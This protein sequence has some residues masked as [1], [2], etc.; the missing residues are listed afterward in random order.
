MNVAGWEVIQDGYYLEGLLLD[1]ETIWYTDIGGSG[2]ERLGGGAHL[3]P[4][5]H[6]IGGLLLNHD[7]CILVSG[8][9]GIVWVDPKSG[10][11]GTLVEG[12]AGINEMR[13]DGRGGILFGTIDLAAI[14]AGEKPGP[15]AIYR[16][17]ADRTLTRLYD[18]LTFTNGLELSPD[19]RTLYLN[20]S[21]ARVLAFDVAEDGSLGPPRTM[22]EK[23][24]CDGM[25]LDA[26]G[27]VWVTGFASAELLCL[28]PDGSVVRTLPLPGPAATNI[29]FGGVDLR[30]LF[31][32]TV[33]PS[34]AQALAEARPL[35]ERNSFLYKTRSPVPG[36]AMAPATFALL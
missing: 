24:D 26:E 21:F 20:E 11:S 2:V 7:G 5:R 25:S 18:G 10:R 13:S 29:R 22:A 27:N 1:G 36:R 6:L 19:A 28:A 15:S 8:L 12:L 9:D 23:Q 14:M 17:S 34:S 32:T 35:T 31:V 16:L 3:L 33:D 4:D 30:D